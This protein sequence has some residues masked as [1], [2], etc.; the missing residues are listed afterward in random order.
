[1]YFFLDSNALLVFRARHTRK[2]ISNLFF[3]RMA[4]FL[5]VVIWYRLTIN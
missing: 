2:E 3:P 1:M 4:S 5:D